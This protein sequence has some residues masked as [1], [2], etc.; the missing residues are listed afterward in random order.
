[1]YQHV[2]MGMAFPQQHISQQSPPA[3]A[4]CARCDEKLWQ[5]AWTEGYN[6]YCH[7][8]VLVELM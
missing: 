6:T 4:S 1:M 2:Q 7:D 5:H 8:L 3:S